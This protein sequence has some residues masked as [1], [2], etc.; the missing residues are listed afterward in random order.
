MEYKNNTWKQLHTTPQRFTTVFFAKFSVILLMTLKFFLFFNIG[1]ILSGILPT[2]IF[3]G[4]L[5]NESIPLMPFLR[6]N[7]NVFLTCL[8]IIAIQY[9]I[10]LNFKNFLVPIGIG[11]LG[12]IGSLIGMMWKYIWVSPYSYPSMMVVK[13]TSIN[14]QLYAFVYFV[15]IM[16]VSYFIYIRKSEKG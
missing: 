12:L 8:P 9:L 2:L 4:S 14:I 10:S 11:L 1:I 16:A 5:P 3:N 15:L 6:G 13:F 7:A